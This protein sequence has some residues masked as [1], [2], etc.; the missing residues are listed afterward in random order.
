[1]AGDNQPLVVVPV[2]DLRLVFTT[3]PVSVKA[4]SISD[5]ITIELQDSTGAPATSAEDISVSLSSNSPGNKKFL[6]DAQGIAEIQGFNIPAG[7][8]DVTIY[9]KDT[10]AT[11]SF[12]TAAAPG[13]TNGYQLVTVT[14]GETARLF[15]PPG[16]ALSD[17]QN[18]IQ[19][20]AS[21][22]ITVQAFDSLNNP[23]LMAADTVIHLSSSSATGS[24]AS[25][26]TNGAWLDGSQSPALTIK[27]GASEGHFYYRD[28]TLGQVL[29]TASSQPEH[30]WTDATQAEMIYAPVITKFVFI[31]PVR[32]VDTNVSSP[33]ITVQTQDVTGNAIPVSSDTPVS[34]ITS[35]PS[36][37]SFS[38]SSSGPW[39]AIAL[40]I[41]AGQS[42]FN[43]YYKDTTP[44]TKTIGISETPSLGWTDA[45]QQITVNAGAVAKLAFVSANQ[46]I[47]RNIASGA[48]IV[49]LED[50]NGYPTV[51]DADLAVAVNT[52]SATGAFSANGATGPWN[53]ASVMIPAGQSTAVFYYRDQQAGTFTL[54]AHAGGQAWSAVQTISVTEGVIGQIVFTTALQS[55]SLNAASSIIN[56]ET[57]DVQGNAVEVAAD[58]AITLGSNSATPQFSAD[59][60]NWGIT[61]VVIPAGA[62]KVGI[63]YKD[64]TAGTFSL[65]AS[66]SP[67]RGWIDG[68]QQIVVGSIEN[69]IAKLKF[70]TAPEV[71]KAAVSGGEISGKITVET[72]SS[73]GNA[74]NV[75][76]VTYLVVNSSNASGKFSSSPAGLFAGTIVLTLLPGKSSADF[77]YTDTIQ[78][79]ATLTVSEFPSVGWTDDTQQIEITS[80]A[81]SQLAFTT[82]P[83]TLFTNA[84]SGIITIEPRD[85]YGNASRVGSDTVIT[86]NS[87]SGTGVFY[88]NV[89]PNALPITSVTIP[90][91]GNNVSFYYADKTAGTYL[92]TAD[93]TP[94]PGWAAATQSIT[95]GDSQL[96]KL[97]IEPD[98]AL[99]PTNTSVQMTA[100]GYNALGDPIPNLVIDWSVSNP[101]AGSITNAGVLTTGGNLGKYA[102]VVTASSQG[103]VAAAPS[104]KRFSFADLFNVAQAAGLV[105]ADATVEVYKAPAA[106]PATPPEPAPP[107]GVAGSGGFLPS[108]APAAPLPPSN[109][110][111]FIN[112]GEPETLYRAVALSLYATNASYLKISEFSD[113]HDAA[114]WLPYVSSKN[115]TLSDGY[116]K[117]TVYA[118]YENAQGDESGVV[119]AIIY[120]VKQATAPAAPPVANI[121]NEIIK[122][123][124]YVIVNAA[125]AA[126]PALPVVLSPAPNSYVMKNQLRMAGTAL[127]NTVVTLH[128]HGT[129]REVA[130]AVTDANGTFVYNFEQ[131]EIVTGSYE[132]Y[133]SIDQPHGSLVGPAVSFNVIPF[134]P[135]IAAPQASGFS[136]TGS[137]LF[138]LALW[139]VVI[140]LIIFFLYG[141][142]TGRSLNVNFLAGFF[143]NL[144]DLTWWRS[145]PARFMSSLKRIW[146]GIRRKF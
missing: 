65:S 132:T 70:K 56:I 102:S 13:I 131:N 123:Y 99:L 49:A 90:A 34:L 128:I 106:A 68:T 46:S 23:T 72:E 1:L 9:Y 12:I 92:L 22:K 55:I 39:N 76:Q 74:V 50:A 145:L 44:G 28:G 94:S 122:K 4:G 121:V 8:S 27:A 41:P 81:I 37:G 134:L 73:F 100:I 40:T 75:T 93:D 91:N 62:H 97:V 26:V 10:S 57:E 71:G 118:K 114:E 130:K 17:G 111:L 98:Y 31:T 86:L 60:A 16:S 95:V 63:Y 135:T 33:I 78:G 126:T 54:R 85:V 146:Q 84:N 133:V 7:Q 101:A 47:A 11:T 129:Q 120:Y 138:F 96:A 112:D 142:L 51:Y 52:D 24:F 3:P 83:Q 117:K 80:G 136:F 14:A 30:G 125:G 79:I 61:S 143:M 144:A 139:F 2:Y 58:T 88:K 59:G 42:S 116:G 67:S 113:F 137:L 69:T 66:E 43:F 6:F 19:N 64:G 141:R 108:A 103:L 21:E 53:V 32:A 107:S 20:Y 127:P 77:Y 115:Y 119:N 140:L 38:A 5:P 48:I 25:N 109:L 45:T 36:G 18:I 124:N 105:T 29:L 87:T 89:G 110:M 104:R 35:N 82:L 15:I